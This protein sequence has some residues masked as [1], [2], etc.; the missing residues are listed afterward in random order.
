MSIYNIGALNI[1]YVYNVT[2]FVRPGETLGVD[3]FDIF[4][5]GKGLNQSIALKK[6]GA[7]VVFCGC[8][9][10]DG[11][12]LV[13]V[14]QE[15]GLDDTHVRRKDTPSG[16]TIIQVDESGQNSILLYAG[17]NHC[18]DMSDIEIALKGAKSGD[19][20]LLQNE[21]NGLPEIF[22][23]AHKKGLQIVFNPSPFHDNIWELPLEYVG[24]WLLNET[25]GR[26]LSGRSETKEILNT[27]QERYPGS[28]IL[29]TLGAQ[30]SVFRDGNQEFSQPVFPVKA[31]DTTGAGDTYTG[32]FLA[33]LAEGRPVTEAMRRAAAA[34]AIVVSRMGAASA[35]PSLDEVREFLEK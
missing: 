29:L 20:L 31:A 1:D 33:S 23:L 2:H 11:A 14:L 25:E 16:H 12:F 4:P 24:L 15:A 13:K 17:A 30:G 10:D 7:D 18:I 3:M 21:I 9:G 34:S 19:M 35:I 8:I 28:R 32:F 22:A 6:A 5:G 26:V 27:L